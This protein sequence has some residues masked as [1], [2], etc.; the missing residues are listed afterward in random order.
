MTEQSPVAARS[1]AAL[2]VAARILGT[3][4]VGAQVYSLLRERIIRT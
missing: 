2:P 3:A 4:P 1:P